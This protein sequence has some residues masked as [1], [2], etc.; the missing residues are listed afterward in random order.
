VNEV[1]PIASTKYRSEQMTGFAA[2]NP[3]YGLLNH[4]DESPEWT[5]AIEAAFTMHRLD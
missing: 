3:S 5:Y 1:K 2:L 4:C